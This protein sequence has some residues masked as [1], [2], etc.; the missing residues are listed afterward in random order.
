[1]KRLYVI[2]FVIALLL[3]LASSFIA[4]TDPEGFS[5]KGLPFAYT[6]TID[7]QGLCVAYTD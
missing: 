1:M 7:T 6:K 3:F 2:S 5:K 4:Y